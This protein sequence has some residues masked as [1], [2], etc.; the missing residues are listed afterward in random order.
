MEQ[1]EAERPRVENE[2]TKK[3]VT[4]RAELDKMTTELTKRDQEI[5]L[6]LSAMTPAPPPGVQPSIPPE[7]NAFHLSLHAD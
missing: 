3:D 1:D 6:K 5:N 7:V 2:D 4:L